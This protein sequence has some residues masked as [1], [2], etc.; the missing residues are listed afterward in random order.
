MPDSCLGYMSPEACSKCGRHSCFSS[1]TRYIKLNRA[2]TFENG[3]LNLVYET[4]LNYVS[5]IIRVF[6]TLKVVFKL[7]ALVCDT[8]RLKT[9]NVG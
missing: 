5:N 4:A 3:H 8:S 6:Y 1:S 9:K 7:S 2:F